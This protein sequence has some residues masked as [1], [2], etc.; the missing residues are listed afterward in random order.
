MV[1][2][3]GFE[4]ATPTMRMWCAP[5]CATGPFS[6]GNII[7]P[8]L[9]DVKGKKTGERC[10]RGYGEGAAVTWA[11]AAGESFLRED[12]RIGAAVWASA[13]GDMEKIGI[14]IGWRLRLWDDEKEERAGEG[15]L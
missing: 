11:S 3:T 9:G 2:L 10:I 12:G 1:D 8:G 7:R 6:N 14:A 4:P 15:N 13:A 5:S